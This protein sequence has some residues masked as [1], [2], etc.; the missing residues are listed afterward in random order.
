MKY[1]FSKKHLPE[2]L[3]SSLFPISQNVDNVRIESCEYLSGTSKAGRPYEAI[4]FVFSRIGESGKTQFLNHKCWGIDE[5]TI[6]PKPGE[7]LSQAV[8][9]AYQNFNASL[10]HISKS[11]G[12]HD[13]RFLSYEFDTLSELA[14][15]YCDEIMENSQDQSFY[16][17]TLSDK[18]GYIKVGYR[19]FIQN[20]NE[21]QPKLSY[22][23][24]E[25]A[26]FNVTPEQGITE[27]V[28]VEEDLHG[29][30]DDDF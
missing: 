6:R 30:D 18:K 2:G 13:E 4:D 3:E 19:P 24:Y 23:K 21:G 7:S 9:K 12:I 15:L 27:E 20:M 11:C 8:N 29:Y 10:M 1:G 25:L 22:S 17:K 5:D 28:A 26:N 14:A 16:L